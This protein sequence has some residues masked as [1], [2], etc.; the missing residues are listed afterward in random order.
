MPKEK[1]SNSSQQ[2]RTRQQQ[3]PATTAEPY[4]WRRVVFGCL[5]VVLCWSIGIYRQN[6]DAADAKA[7]QLQDWAFSKLWSHMSAQNAERV[8]IYRKP[9]WA[10][11]QGNVFEIGAG[12]GEPLMLLP[13]GKNGL[14]KDGT[15]VRGITQ[16]IAAEPNSFLHERLAENAAAAGFAVQYDANTSPNGAEF[17]A[18]S[19]ASKLPVLTIV[20]GTLDDAPAVIPKY[21]RDHAPYDYAIGSMVMCSVDNVQA[22]LQA[23][24]DLLVPGGKFIFIEHVRHT[25]EADSTVRAEYKA[26][27]MDVSM[28]RRAQEMLTS[29]WRLFTGNCH[30]D[31]DTGKLIR[32]MK[33]WS[34]VEMQTHRGT[35]GV[36]DKLTP[37]V[38][39]IAT[40]AA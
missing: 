28:W 3:R 23:I 8:D 14:T 15:G 29:V 38:F 37:L 22:N 6:K 24:Q 5:V 19:A 11:V 7:K 31:R 34:S 35:S 25:D 32:E 17:N 33:G 2:Q 13:R 39:G 36:L 4:P 20:N 26:G 16:Y 1:E 27:S 10:Q 12:H 30:L 18:A 21:I 9:L 40:K